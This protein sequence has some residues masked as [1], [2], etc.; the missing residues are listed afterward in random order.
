MS[1]VIKEISISAK[2]FAGTNYKRLLL[3]L[4]YMVVHI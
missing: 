2:E 3:A 4:V 1:N